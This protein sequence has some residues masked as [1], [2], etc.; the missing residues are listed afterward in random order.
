MVYHII[1]KQYKMV[2]YKVMLFAQKKAPIKGAYLK[3]LN[4]LIA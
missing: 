1:S 4:V 2:N 3:A